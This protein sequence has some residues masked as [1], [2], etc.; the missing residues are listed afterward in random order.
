[1]GNYGDSLA[2]HLK[3]L[4]TEVGRLHELHKTK[5]QK[6]MLKWKELRGALGNL[7]FTYIDIAPP[8]DRLDG[9]F[10]EKTRSALRT[11]QTLLPH[12]K[13]AV[14]VRESLQRFSGL[15]SSKTIEEVLQ[16]MQDER[17]HHT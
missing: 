3:T 1:M 7:L 15:F 6:D 2:S 14:I 11:A 8:G 13:E 5:S 16:K 4:T 9:P 10:F 17:E 12:T